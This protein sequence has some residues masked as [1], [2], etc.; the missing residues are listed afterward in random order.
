MQLGLA[1]AGLLLS[2]AIPLLLVTLAMPRF[3]Q[4]LV[5]SGRVVD[6]VHKRPPT[7][8]P[9]PVGPL[10]FLGAFAGEIIAYLGLRFACPS[11]GDR[12]CGG[13]LCN[14]PCR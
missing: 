14:R 13:R 1:D 11:G 2:F 6:D 10:L 12:G 4:C 9:L 5:K 8:V 7:K 3:I